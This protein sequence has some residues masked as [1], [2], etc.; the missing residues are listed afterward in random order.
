MPAACTATSTPL[1]LSWPRWRSAPQLHW[2]AAFDRDDWSKLCGD[3]VSIKL[4]ELGVRP[5]TGGV[6]SVHAEGGFVDQEGLCGEAMG[7]SLLDSDTA[8]IQEN[9]LLSLK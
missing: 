8:A 2:N 1:A 3:R 4:S 9:S 6:Q 7:A 5:L